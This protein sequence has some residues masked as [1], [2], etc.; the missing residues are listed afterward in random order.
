MRSCCTAETSTSEVGYVTRHRAIG[1][2]EVFLFNVDCL[3]FGFHAPLVSY[4]TTRHFDTMSTPPQ[5]KVTIIG[6]GIAGLTC[7]LA[8]RRNGHMVTLLEKS[9]FHQETGAAMYV[10]PNC[11]GHLMRLGWDPAS[12]R[13]NL[14][15]GVLSIFGPT[16]EVKNKM[17]LEAVSRQWVNPWLLVHRGDLHEALKR[18]VR[19]PEGKGTPVGLHLGV[20]IVEVDADGARVVLNTGEILE[21]DVIIGADGN[22]SIARKSVDPK[23]VLRPWGKSCYRFLMERQVLKAN[24]ETKGLVEEDG[25]FLDV[26][27]NDRKLVAYPCRGNTEV[28]VAAFLPDDQTGG[29]GEGELL[30][31]MLACSS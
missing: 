3:S 21:S 9:L 24:E 29:T 30:A 1:E 17:G 15:E 2:L 7:A 19:D 14:C 5:L 4:R 18:L 8:L 22:N 6:A 13:A 11:S 25:Y 26:L 16:G 27:A 10:G 12:T 23:A 20:K 28:N 31:V